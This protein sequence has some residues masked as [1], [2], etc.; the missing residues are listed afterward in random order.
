MIPGNPPDVGEK[1]PGRL[2]GPCLSLESP[3]P[4]IIP[5]IFDHLEGIS[6]ISTSSMTPDI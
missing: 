5:Y 6:Q 3:L 4:G 1:P 2:H